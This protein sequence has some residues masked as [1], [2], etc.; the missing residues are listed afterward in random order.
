MREV[1]VAVA[2]A[3]GLLVVRH[4]VVERL[5]AGS[6][7]PGQAAMILAAYWASLPLAGAVLGLWPMNAVTISL[8]VAIGIG[9]AVGLRPVLGAIKRRDPDP[10]DAPR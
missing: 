6:M 2:L 10:G 5:K 9:L 8:A 4:V 1:A 3:I 7:S